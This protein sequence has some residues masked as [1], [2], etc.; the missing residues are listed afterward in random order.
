MACI[1]ILSNPNA[2]HRHNGDLHTALAALA[3]SYLNIHHIV[4]RDLAQV[5]NTLRIFQ[6]LGVE[7]LVSDGGDGALSELV[8]H[9]FRLRNGVI[10]SSDTS[11]PLF[12]PLN[13]GTVNVM[14]NHLGIAGNPLDVLSYLAS[15]SINELRAT[16]K[17]IPALEIAPAGEA[18]RYGFIYGNG[19]VYTVFELY[20]DAIQRSSNAFWATM[21]ILGSLV[22]KKTRA[23]YRPVELV[24]QRPGYEN[25]RKPYPYT[26]MVASTRDLEVAVPHLPFR[27]FD[28]AQE[29]YLH[30]VTTKHHLRLLELLKQ[31]WHLVRGEKPDGPLM[32]NSFVPSFDL[33][34]RRADLAYQLDGTNYHLAGDQDAQTSC[35]VA[36][37]PKVLLVGMGR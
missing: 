13:T 33:T 25:H 16:S 11:A 19:V 2:N 12:V 23:L 37:G 26:G 17:S 9:E 3:Y 30:L 20:Q 27:L 35:R 32:D 4:T 24:L 10:Q 15:R 34:G 18:K 21:R 1:G 36:V 28:D 14:A 8:T 6:N 7:V 31:G 22:Y 29:G 5:S